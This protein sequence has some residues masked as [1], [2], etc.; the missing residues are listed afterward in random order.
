M[1]SNLFK[2]GSL[3][4]LAYGTYLVFEGFNT[5]SKTKE[6]IKKEL[7]RDL[8]S[9]SAAKPSPCVPSSIHPLTPETSRTPAPLLLP[10]TITSP[11]DLEL[12][13]IYRNHLNSPLLKSLATPAP[14]QDLVRAHHLDPLKPIEAK[15]ITTSAPDTELV[16]AY[17][18]LLKSPWSKTFAAPPPNQDVGSAHDIDPPKAITTPAPDAPLP[19]RAEPNVKG[20][21]PVTFDCDVICEALIESRL[22]KIEPFVGPP[23]GQ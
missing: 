20:K 14:S 4:A 21:A 1:R 18:N 5:G 22:R 19:M 7:E 3:G 11:S 23:R 6:Q 12:T 9:L 2:A 16:K 10:K 15:T 8:S 17:D 13:R